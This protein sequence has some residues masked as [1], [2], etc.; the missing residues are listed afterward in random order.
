MYY[1]GKFVEFCNLKDYDSLISIN[2]DQLQIMVE[3]Y[4]MSLKKRV[5]PNSIPTYL[6]GIQTFFES[7]DIE[8]NWKKIRR[9]YPAKVKVS[10]A[11]AYTTQQI[12]KMLSLIP[13]LRNKTVI[14]F[15]AAS[16][17][18]VGALSELKIK[19]FSNMPLGCKSVLIYEGSTEEY[20]T[21]LTPEAS[22]TLE[23]YFEQRI[24]DGEK[25]NMESP[26]FREDYK[27]GMVPA[28]PMS[29][30]AIINM[31]ERV[32][33][34][35]GI[36]ETKKGKRYDIQLDHG[37]RKRWNTIMKT[38]D[39]MKI[40]LVEK[41]FGHSTPS[42]PLDETYMVPSVE[43]LFEEYKKAI[44]ELTIDDSQ[45][46]DALLKKTLEEK[47]ELEK[48][49]DNVVKMIQEQ[50]KAKDDI[51]IIVSDLKEKIKKLEQKSES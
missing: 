45:R 19:H 32:V 39:G 6:Y 25:L 30:K 3:D 28:K 42:I 35:A 24:K 10:G 1:L 27:F 26:I 36:R 15:I 20:S 47:S 2:R 33:K 38:T 48:E 12:Q 18:R 14:H 29:R 22:K 16:G 46:K 8:L 50:Q 49:K 7:N 21:F 43:K 34:N 41:M 5:N 17:C 37:F 44:Y 23:D 4:V 40:I 11:K 51:M 9:L 31:M 13:S